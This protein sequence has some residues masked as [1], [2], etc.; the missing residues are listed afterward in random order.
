MVLVYIASWVIWS[1]WYFSV[2]YAEIKRMPNPDQLSID[3]WLNSIALV[4][5]LAGGFFQ[6]PRHR[7]QP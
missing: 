5:T 6:K 1:L 3:M 2:H 7:L 4:C